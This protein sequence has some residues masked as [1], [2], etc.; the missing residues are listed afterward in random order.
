MINLKDNRCKQ[1]F[2]MGLDQCIS[3]VNTT[4][5]LLDLILAISIDFCQQVNTIFGIGNASIF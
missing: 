1:V 4:V 2:Q 5:C 3:I